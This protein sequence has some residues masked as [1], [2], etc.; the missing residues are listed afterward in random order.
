MSTTNALNNR[1]PAESRQLLQLRRSRDE[2]DHLLRALS[3]DMTANF[4]LLESSFKRLKR[5]LAQPEHAPLH[6]LTA[7]MEACL[8]ESKRFLDDI[9]VLARTGS[10]QM[11]P[12]TVE[13]EGVVDEVLFEQRELL[14]A[15]GIQ[16]AVCRPMAAVRCHRQRLKQVLTNLLRNAVKHGCHP[17]H[18]TITLSAEPTADHPSASNGLAVVIRVHDNGPGIPACFHKEIFLPGRRLDPRPEEGAG[19]GLAIVRKIAEYYGGTA[20]VDAECPEGTAILVRLPAAHEPLMRQT[21][22]GRTIEG[23]TRHHRG[24][25]TPHEERRPHRHRSDRRR[26]KSARPR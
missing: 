18:P 19:M 5:A 3:H 12:E 17:V 13:V 22:A 23:G 25:D 16:V 26:W 6:D 1:E 4:M 8:R 7:H 2:M 21:A 14:N 10:V 24:H 11:E 15:R 9:A 20:T